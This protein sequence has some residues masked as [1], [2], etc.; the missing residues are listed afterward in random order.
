M[1]PEHKAILLWAIEQDLARHQRNQVTIDR[2]KRLNR[3][4]RLLVFWNR[5]CIGLLA[6][7]AMVAWTLL[8]IW[9]A[10]RHAW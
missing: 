10:W 3:R 5:N 9:L 4:Q 2:L 7:L 6:C 8:S 1:T